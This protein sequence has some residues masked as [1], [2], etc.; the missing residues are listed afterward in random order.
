MKYPKMQPDK[1]Y[2]V[3][4]PKLDGGV[5]MHDGLTQV[6]DNQLTDCLNMWWKDGMLQT[7][8]GLVQNTDSLLSTSMANNVRFFGGKEEAANS[9]G[10]T[11]R[12]IVKQ[13][14][15]A[16]A[17]VG[18]DYYLCEIYKD[19]KE[20]RK[21]IKHAYTENWDE[22]RFMVLENSGKQYGNMI[23]NGSIIFMYNGVNG[24]NQILGETSTGFEDISQYAYVPLV[25]ING[26]AQD[27]N[28]SVSGNLFEGYNLLTPKFKA[29]FTT[30]S[31]KSTFYMPIKNLDLD[32]SI[33]VTYTNSEGKQTTYIVPEGSER[34]GFINGISVRANRPGGYVYTVGETGPAS[35]P[36]SSIRNNL[37]VIAKKTRTGS[38]KKIC[39]MRFCTW[40]GGDRSGYNGGTR[41]FVSGNPS[42][43]NLVH[44]SDINNPLY[45]SENNYAHIGNAAQAVTALAKQG[46]KLVIFKQHEMFYVNYVAGQ[47]YTADDVIDGK[48]IDVTTSSAYFPVTQIHPFIGCDCPNT[49]QLC[50]NRLVWATSDRKIYALAG[51][52]QFS[53]NNVREISQ[54]IDSQLSNV[55]GDITAAT[56]ADYQGHY[57]LCVGKDVFLLNYADGGYIQYVTYGMAKA[58]NNIKW[59]KWQLLS[60]GANDYHYLISNGEY[61]VIHKVVSYSTDGFNNDYTMYEFNC[62]LGGTNDCDVSFSPFYFKVKE[63]PSMFQTKVFDFSAPERFKDVSQ[64][65]IGVG[66]GA[67]DIAATYL[68][69]KGETQ[70]AILSPNHA[71][72][73]AR[74]PQNIVIRRLTPNTRRIMR[75][76]IRLESAGAMAVDSL[77]LKY[78]IH[79]GSVR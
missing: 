28:T 77:V 26:E 51:A 66:S 50:D 55:Q 19:G 17:S 31:N 12:K 65:Y 20:N 7:R 22:D 75:F 3:T 78:T 39:N 24:T 10:G 54:N 68:T 15:K 53:E 42:E 2:R 64:V 6:D 16:G 21:L 4:V 74:S 35:F 25:L 34:S 44:W 61:M 38:I 29:K 60:F 57:A 18:T 52:N 67:H 63:I 5:N 1:S 56:S 8:P 37:E 58:Q 43:P 40:F 47:T 11:C 27:A 30:I 49:I 62:T 46:E 33:I 9:T 76:G 79:G 71:Q 70:D 23:Q 59:T 36:T 48:I 69:N 41:L 13:I 32:D 72:V 14:R 73:D 45:F